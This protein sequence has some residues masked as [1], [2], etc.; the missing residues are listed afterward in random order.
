MTEYNQTHGIPALF[1]FIVPGFGQ[2]TKGHIFKAFLFFFG[3]I[4]GLFLL[5]I[6][7]IFIWLIGIYDAYNSN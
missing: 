3:F 2:L 6:P 7:G 4:F 5:I 1:S